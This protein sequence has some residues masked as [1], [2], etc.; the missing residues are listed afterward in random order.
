MNRS[1]FIECLSNGKLFD[2]E[3]NPLQLSK[4][5][6]EMDSFFKTFSLAIYGRNIFNVQLRSACVLRFIMLVFN[7]PSECD[8]VSK[9]LEEYAPNCTLRKNC[10]SDEAIQMWVRRKNSN[11]L[12]VDAK[13][14]YTR[15]KD[16]M[17]RAAIEFVKKNNRI[18]YLSCRFVF[19]YLLVGLH[20]VGIH[21]YDEIKDMVYIQ[22]EIYRAR[23]RKYSSPNQQL[24]SQSRTHIYVWASKSN[25]QLLI[26]LVQRKTITR[27]QHLLA[28]MDKTKRE[29]YQ[30]RVSQGQVTNTSVSILRPLEIDDAIH[31]CT[32]SSIIPDGIYQ[33]YP[34]PGLHFQLHFE[35]VEKL[36]VYVIRESPSDVVPY[37][38]CVLVMEHDITYPY[39]M[40]RKDTK[41]VI[42]TIS[43]D[44][45]ESVTRYLSEKVHVYE[46]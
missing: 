18:G 43:K 25:F 34:A 3:D 30:L 27:A 23:P 1:T 9:F 15:D 32:M 31:C 24:I 40:L 44:P 16:G 42:V 4:E 14:Y 36:Y 38:E 21:Y 29:K 17:R 45:Q 7:V 13:K 28:Q 22:P 39:F 33:I 2:V 8:S 6:P 5:H 10:H 41:K 19:A 11:T 37:L 26:P 35:P 12:Y 46:K 20:N